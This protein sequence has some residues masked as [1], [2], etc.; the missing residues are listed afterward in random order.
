VDHLKIGVCNIQHEPLKNKHDAANAVL[1]DNRFVNDVLEHGSN[2]GFI[3]HQIEEDIFEI[4][5]G[6]KSC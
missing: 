2:L 1:R 4:F 3:I 6:R 5:Q